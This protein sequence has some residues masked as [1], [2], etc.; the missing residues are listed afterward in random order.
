[1]AKKEDLTSSAVNEK[2]SNSLFS[3][4]KEGN[5]LTKET[6]E[7][8]ANHQYIAAYKKKEPYLPAQPDPNT[9]LYWH[10]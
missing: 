5:R 7:L 1:M 9:K 6:E 3:K 4:D 2:L 10:P 8:E